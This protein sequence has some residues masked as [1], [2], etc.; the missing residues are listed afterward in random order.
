MTISDLFLKLEAGIDIP[1]PELQLICHSPTVKEIAL[2]GESDFFGAM[3]FLCINKEVLPQ[4]ETVLQTLTNFQILMKVLKESQD[5]DRKA[6]L[7]TL[8]TLLFP[9]YQ[10]ALM[11]ASINFMSED[12]VIMV[13]NENFDLFQDVIKKVLCVDSLFQS[14]NVVYNTKSKKAQEIAEKIYKGRNKV[15]QI[16][17]KEGSGSILLRYLSILQIGPRIPLSESVNFNLFQLFDTIERY[18]AYTEWDTDLQVRLAGGKPDKEVESWMKEL[19][20][21]K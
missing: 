4:S 3:Q 10:V 7:V 17:A 2:M 11:P 8:L 18:T 15:A 19:H 13:D 9:D 1:I 16:K 5:K 12:D 21:N 14:D 6:S 20:S